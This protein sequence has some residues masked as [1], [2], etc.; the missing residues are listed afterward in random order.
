MESENKAEI[1]LLRAGKFFHAWNK[2]AYFFSK[3]F[4]DYQVHCRFVKKIGVEMYYLGFPTSTLHKIQEIAEFKKMEFRKVDDNHYVISHFIVYTDYEKWAGDKAS[5]QKTSL[6]E[7]VGRT[8][9][10]QS[11]VEAIHSG[12]K[13]TL[14]HPERSHDVAKSKDLTLKFSKNLAYAH[15]EFYECTR[16]IIGRTSEMSRS[17]RVTLVERLRGECFDLLDHLD[18]CQM[19][20]DI[21]NEKF[22]MRKFCQ[23]REKLRL[24]MDLKQIAPR[25]WFFVSEKIEGVKKALRLQSGDSRASGECQPES[26]SPLTPTNSNNPEQG[27]VRV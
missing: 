23:I 20:L 27:Y 7:T 3:H 26:S 16:Y 1:H 25:Q 2:S 5:E 4:F 10:E 13:E 19:G 24:L 6:R 18:F 17:M 9:H 22:A 15:K 14:C 12:H 8:C 11:E 21:F